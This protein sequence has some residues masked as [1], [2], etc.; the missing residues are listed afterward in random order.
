M[1]AGEGG[2]DI[3]DGEYTSN[4]GVGGG[5]GFDMPGEV[6]SA[7]GGATAAAGDGDARGAKAVRMCSCFPSLAVSVEVSA[8]IRSALVTVLARRCAR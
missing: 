8:Q 3:A 5:I 7:A 4:G 2:M 6:E 1:A